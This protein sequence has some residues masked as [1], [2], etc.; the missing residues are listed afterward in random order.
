M[1]VKV[2]QQQGKN[3]WGQSAVC[4][5]STRIVRITDTIDHARYWLH[6][7]SMAQAELHEKSHATRQLLIHCIEPGHVML[8]QNHACVLVSTAI[9]IVLLVLQR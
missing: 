1:G 2:R 8:Q 5:S 9:K 3:S 7:N 4:T 6:N